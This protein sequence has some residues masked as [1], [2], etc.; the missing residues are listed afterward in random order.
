MT[1]VFI[2]YSHEDEDLKN[3]FVNHLSALK[4]L[5]TVWDD[6]QILIG[7]K[8]D[9]TIKA[10]LATSEI[11]IFLISSD[12]L[13]STYVNEVELNKTIER[14]N[15]GEVYLI[16]VLL[17][18]CLFESNILGSFQAVPRDAKFITTQSS[19]D[20]GFLE[21]IKEIK[22]ILEFFKPVKR[23]L[24]DETPL[25]KELTL[26][27]LP[28]DIDKWVGRQEELNILN[29]RLFKVVFITGFG[30]QGKSSLAARYIL[31]QEKSDYWDY[32]DWRDFREEDNMLRTKL[33]D[34]MKRFSD[35]DYSQ[36]YLNDSTYDEFI[37]LFFKAIED[38]K[39]ILVFDNIDSYIDYEKFV[40]TEGISRLVY[41]ALNRKHECK[42]IFTCRPFIKQADVGFYQIGLKGLKYE[43]TVELLDKYQIN[44]KKEMR[45]ELYSELHQITNGHPMWLNILGAQAVRGVDKLKEFLSGISGHTR[46][47]ELSESKILSEH[48]LGALW[49]SLNPKQKKLLR[50]L[51][52]LVRAEETEEIAKI[53]SDELKWNQ[54]TRAL[55]NLKLLNLVVT[56]KKEGRDEQVELHPLVKNF[57]K[58][59]FPPSERNKYISIIIKYYDSLTVVLKKRMSGNQ[60]L[61]F[62][63]NW[64]DKVELAVNKQ[65]FTKALSTLHEISQPIRTAGY[66]EEYLRVSKLTF[67]MIDFKKMISDEIPY[68]VSQL[69][70]LID[71]CSELSDFNYARELLDQFSYNIKEKGYNYVVRCD[72]ESRY[73]FNKFD[74]K[75]SINWGQIGLDLIINSNGSIN[76]DIEHTLNLS[77]RDSREEP[78]IKEALEYFMAGNSEEHILAP[79]IDNDLE[80]SLYGN[81]GRCFYFLKEYDKALKCYPKS[82][83]LCYLE[84]TPRKYINRGYISYWLAQALQRKGENR[85]G[86]FFFA[87]CLKYWKKYSPHRATR[88]EE[89]LKLLTLEIPD[90]EELLKTDDDIIES[91]CKDYCVKAIKES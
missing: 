73:Y 7:T 75:Q 91:Q 45:D 10:K 21:A 20:L 46:F 30:G 43:N 3:Q 61:D 85:L 82:F 2:S 48:I 24:S 62:Y 28:P 18:P 40:P 77:K 39:I 57:V 29:K 41:H 11:V 64:T 34:I 6:R 19:I 54:F 37:E 44:L 59:K 51:S 35:R 81:V 90:V 71:L 15:R 66:F 23:L 70:V 53:V 84:E 65:D 32:W 89:E 16:P 33:F 27:D 67:A 78:L 25:K 68:F 87:N 9:E 8:W 14:H 69:C 5:I 42:F 4:D 49:E 36:I 88:V 1:E 80:A 31:D 17:R 52:E 58:S 55:N 83:N 26:C 79:E 50:C 12:F 13:A 63:Q 72:L 56:K 86:Y 74:Y 76:F 60:S 47:D 22:S 38:K